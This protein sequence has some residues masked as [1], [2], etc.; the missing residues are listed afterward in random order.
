M[1]SGRP[2]RP[3]AALPFAGDLGYSWE[4][5]GPGACIVLVVLACNSLGDAL[6]EILE[7]RIRSR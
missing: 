6:R 4:I 5:V 2:S 1:R 3:L 7:T